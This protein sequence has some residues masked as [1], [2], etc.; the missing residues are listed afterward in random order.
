MISKHIVM[1]LVFSLLITLSLSLDIFFYSASLDK[2]RLDKNCTRKNYFIKC[3]CMER[4]CYYS[5]LSSEIFGYFTIDQHYRN[6]S[7]IV[8]YGYFI[9]EGIVNVKLYKDHYPSISY[10]FIPEDNLISIA[11]VC[12]KE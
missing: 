4:K 11:F 10:H 6:F 5:F 1:L 3:E 12:Q 2:I 9:S 8:E 7:D